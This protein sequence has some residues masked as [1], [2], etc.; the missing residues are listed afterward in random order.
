MRVLISGAAGFVGSHLVQAL[1]KEDCEVFALDTARNNVNFGKVNADNWIDCDISNKAAVDYVEKNLGFEAV[2]H[3]AAIANPN[4]AQANPHLAFAVN[5]LGTYNMLKMAKAADAKRFILASSAHVYGIS[6][7]YMPTDEFHP[8][9]LLDTYT[10]SKV[11]SEKLC[12]FF[13]NSNCHLSYC[14][15]RL[16]NGYGPGQ[17][18]GYFI[19]DMIEKAKTG[20]ITLNGCGITKDFVYI[21]DI[22]DAMIRALESCYVG[23]LNVGT[24]IQTKLE[25]VAAII[26]KHFKAELI[27]G[28]RL[29]N[30]K[31]PTCM[32][33]DITRIKSTLNW[34]P[35]TKIEDGLKATIKATEAS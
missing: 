11:L 5:V 19:P 21:D 2:I 4:F 29:V 30:D 35:Q 23:P 7:K 27:V 14:T 12:E 28:L 9:A 8:L 32:Q 26:A 16:F 17:S 34:R 10:T 13:Y 6:P 18:T 22:V 25:D 33:A 24:G 20:K 3:L 15:L 31:G 1:M